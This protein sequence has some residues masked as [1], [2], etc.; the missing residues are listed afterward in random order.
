[1]S[2]ND[3]SKKIDAAIARSRGAAPDAVVDVT[4]IDPDGELEVL[5]AKAEVFEISD[6]VRLAKQ[7]GC[8]RR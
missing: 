8:L 3:K 1:M 4:T 2:S 6:L 7:E 5:S